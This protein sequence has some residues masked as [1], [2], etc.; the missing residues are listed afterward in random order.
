LGILERI[1]LIKPHQRD[2]ANRR[3]TQRSRP[4]VSEEIQIVI[5]GDRLRFIHQDDLAEAMR[6]G[7]VTT[8]R[9]SH[10]EPGQDGWQAD[11]RP[12][13]GPVLGPFTRRDTALRAE[14]EW[15][16]ENLIPIPGEQ[17]CPYS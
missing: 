17:V 8:L 1:L 4:R 16:R 2:A 11:L 15:L 7:Q 9:A 12:V 10:V 5:S 14:A 13:N 3:Q 6:V